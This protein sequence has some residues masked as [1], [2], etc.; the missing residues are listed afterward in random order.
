VWGLHKVTQLKFFFITV[1]LLLL[2]VPLG[3][4]SPKVSCGCRNPQGWW[5]I[6]KL[7]FLFPVPPQ[8]GEKALISPMD[9]YQYGTTQT[10]T[11]TVYASPPPHHIYWYWQLEKEC[12]YK[13]RWGS[14]HAL[15]SCCHFAIP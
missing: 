14:P 12:S 4:I 5:T 13:A 8:I 3:L 15:L 9:S 1:S 11:C 10:L 6:Q 2:W 7:C